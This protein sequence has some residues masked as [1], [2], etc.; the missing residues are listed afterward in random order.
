[1]SFFEEFSIKWSGKDYKISNLLESHTLG[2]LKDEIYKLTNVK[3]ERQKL[4]GLK[5]NSG[6]NATNSTLL[7]NL[8]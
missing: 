7:L 1:M 2:D 6:E 8:K 3:Q 4:L 5:T